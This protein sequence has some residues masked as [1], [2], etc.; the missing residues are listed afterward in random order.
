MLFI[1][2][3]GI[4]FDYIGDCVEGGQVMVS[5]SEVWIRPSEIQ[6]VVNGED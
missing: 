3:K 5:I 1:Y 4:V 6:G 2:S